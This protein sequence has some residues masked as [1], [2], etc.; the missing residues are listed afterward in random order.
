[1]EQLRTGDSG[2]ATPLWEGYF[3]YLVAVARG[4][5]RAAP[6]GAADEED[7]ALS[8]FNSFCAGVENGRFPRLDD[9][10][11]LWQVLFVI[12]ARKPANLVRR[13]HREKRGRGRVVHAS[14]L[15]NGEA[16]G[17]D[18]LGGAAGSGQTPAFAARVADECPRLLTILDEGNLRQLA[19]R[20]MEGF[21]NAEIAMKLGKSVPTVER[22]LARIRN[23]W[24]R[25]P[26]E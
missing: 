18:F 13:E 14:V 22:K 12:T 5:L 11:D 3:T 26:S 23:T 2:S 21:T 1:L 8:A 17:E 19:V 9:R 4:K 20:K 25:V 15:S 16:S 7:V 24:E 10:D 6:K